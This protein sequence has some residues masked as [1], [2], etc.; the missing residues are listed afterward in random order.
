MMTGWAGS[1]CFSAMTPIL[2]SSWRQRAAAAVFV[3]GYE[4]E[5]RFGDFNDLCLHALTLGIHL[6][7]D[8]ERSTANLDDVGVDT[9]KISDK[10]RL[11]ENKGVDRDRGHAS[12]RAPH[13][14]DGSGDIALRHDPATEDVTMHICVLGHRY[15]AKNGLTVLGEE[16][17]VLVAHVAAPHLV[18]LES[19][20]GL[21]R[22]KSRAALAARAA[23]PA[24]Y[25]FG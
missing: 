10:D 22:A 8:C 20:H 3:C 15:D 13:G 1:I 5:C 9:E 23:A 6:Y 11:L 14:G 19:S 18:A 17:G 16:D 7:G 25:R 12:A 2:D 24:F 21:L 4:C